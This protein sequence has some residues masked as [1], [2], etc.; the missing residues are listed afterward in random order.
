MYMKIYL[1]L[2]YNKVEKGNGKKFRNNLFN[3]NKHGK[4]ELPKMAKI[5]VYFPH[6]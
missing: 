6:N 1:L 5:A 4:Q 2:L 3:L